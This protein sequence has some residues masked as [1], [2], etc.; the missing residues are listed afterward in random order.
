[1]EQVGDKWWKGGKGV[2]ANLDPRHFS[3]HSGRIGGATRLAEMGVSEGVIRK[4]G[5][6]RSDAFR[7]YVRANM[8]QPALVSRVLEARPREIERQLGQGT[9]FR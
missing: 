9:V 8:E 5:R 3:L 7:V 6:W 2:R 1:M 4:E